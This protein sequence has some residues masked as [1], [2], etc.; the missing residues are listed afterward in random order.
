MA[1]TVSMVT[2]AVQYPW[3]IAKRK[4]VYHHDRIGVDFSGIFRGCCCYSPHHH[5]FQCAKAKEIEHSLLP[6]P[7]SSLAKLGMSWGVR[8]GSKRIQG[9][10]N[11]RCDVGISKPCSQA[12]SPLQRWYIWHVQPEEPPNL[13]RDQGCR[14]LGLRLCERS[15]RLV[16]KV[17]GPSVWRFA[18]SH[19]TWWT[20]AREGAFLGPVKFWKFGYRGWQSL[21]LSLYIYTHRYIFKGIRHCTWYRSSVFLIWNQLCLHDLTYIY[22][23][24][25][26]SC[27]STC[28]FGSRFPFSSWLPCV[29]FHGN[30]RPK[31]RIHHH[32]WI[33]D[34]S[35]QGSRATCPVAVIHRNP[36]VLGLKTVIQWD[37]NWCN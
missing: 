30:A 21:S 11:D 25:I 6:E 19:S 18:S 37:H 27:T 5:A 7:K 10:E 15:F 32:T 14:N 26:A 9:S 17:N 33:L 23:H 3:K 29:A 8:Y 16:P 2:M 24:T 34:C 31:K 22:T 12:S 28:L 13:R 1:M 36:A 20:D 4:V 35:H